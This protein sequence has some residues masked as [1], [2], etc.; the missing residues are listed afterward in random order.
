[1]GRSNVYHLG[2][3]YCVVGLFQQEP[4][5]WGEVEVVMAGE[6]TKGRPL[7]EVDWHKVEDPPWQKT[8]EIPAPLTF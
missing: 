8:T 5:E 4:G 1:M 3:A 7:R 2:T 6:V